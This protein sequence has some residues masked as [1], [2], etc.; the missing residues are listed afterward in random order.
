MYKQTEWKDHVVQYP[1]RRKIT[2]NGDG[3][4]TVE[5]APGEIIQQ[6]T[7]QSATNFNNMEDGIQDSQVAE[8]I[9]L[10]HYL[11]KEREYDERVA[12]LE[13]E[14]VNEVGTISLTNTQKYPFNNS[15]KSVALKKARKTLNYDVDVEI[16]SA[17]GCVGD[18]TIT[19]KQLNGFKIAFEGSAGA[20]TIKYRVKGGLLV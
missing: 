18:I 17:S 12:G 3:T 8:K 2:D 1:D 7:P 10:Q 4:S 9:Y 15:Q 6:G 16:T 13:A 11:Q 14:C 20:V 5:K 19:D